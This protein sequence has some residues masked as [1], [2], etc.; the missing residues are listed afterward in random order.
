[1]YYIVRIFYKGQVE[2]HSIES[3]EDYRQALTR[4][5]NIIATDLNNNEITYSFAALLDENG[6]NM[7]PPFYFSSIRDEE[8][9]EPIYPFSFAILRIFINQQMA[10]SVEYKPILE[11]AY[12]RY[13]SI[14][15]T[16]LANN[17]ISFNFAAIIDPMGYI[18][19]ARSFTKT[20]EPEN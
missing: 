16:D 17:N 3:R 20:I 6:V 19:E 12:K 1:M 2:A 14:I 15:A 18:H 13:Y 8:M 7:V 10:T 11:E 5:H 4:F 9:N